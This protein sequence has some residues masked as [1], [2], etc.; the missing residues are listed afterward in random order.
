MARLL[1]LL[2]GL[3]QLTPKI[4]SSETHGLTKLGMGFRCDCALQYSYDF[5]VPTN[6]TEFLPMLCT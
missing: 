2:G 3:G 5:V 6:Q 4:Y 1:D